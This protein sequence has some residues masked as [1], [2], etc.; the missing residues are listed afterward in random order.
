MWRTICFDQLFRIINKTNSLLRLLPK[1][2][3][4]G[5]R[6]TLCL[7]SGL[8]LSVALDQNES[9]YKSVRTRAK[10]FDLKGQFLGLVQIC[11][12]LD[13]ACPQFAK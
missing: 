9:S 4:R 11:V 6:V 10:Q 12:A 5:F 8:R 2:V 3:L 13:A 7:F 1:T